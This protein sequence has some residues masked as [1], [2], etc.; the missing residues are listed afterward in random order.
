[1][2]LAEHN[3]TQQLKQVL[4]HKEMVNNETADVMATFFKFL[5]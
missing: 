1:M 5:F 3:T 2:T 4:G